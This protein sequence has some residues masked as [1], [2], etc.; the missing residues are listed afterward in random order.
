MNK[1]SILLSLI[2]GILCSIFCLINISANAQ[3]I[4][5]VSAQ[6]RTS[7]SVLVW[8]KDLY[9]PGVVVDDDSIFINKESQRLLN[10]SMYRQLMY[11]ATYTWE[12]AISFIQKQELKKAFWF[13]INLYLINDKNKELVV[14]S[15]LMY[16]KVFKMEKI[17]VS[18]FYT[19][20]LTDPEVGTIEEGHSKI[21]APHIME[22]KLNALKA[23]LF[24]LDKYKPADRK[25]DVKAH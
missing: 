19:Y 16:D 2:T 24:Y 6:N 14:K 22:K 13:F 21:T 1:R 9:E 15:I 25:E 7:D 23:M 8:L 17:L 4:K 5:A 12:G 10:D 11:P 18:T 3:N 20:S